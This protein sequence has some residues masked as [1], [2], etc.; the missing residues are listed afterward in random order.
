M[1]SLSARVFGLPAARVAL[2]GREADLEAVAELLTRDGVKLLTLTGAG[3]S[4]KTSLAL[5]VARRVGACF[6]QV[7]F[8]ELGAVTDCDAAALEIANVLG[9]RQ[10]D[11]RPRLLVLDNLEQIHGI[12]PLL[13]RLLD[14]SACLKLLVTSR[15]LLRI[16]PETHYLVAPLRVP[17]PQEA[18][19]P[20]ALAVNPAVALFMQ[21]AVAIEPSFRL[22]ADNAAAVAELCTQLDGL[23]L[24]LEL[25]AARIQVLSPAELLARM[26]SR[27]AL[28][29]T[30][31]AD[32]PPRHQTLRHTLDWSHALLDPRE[33]RLF[34]RLAVF[35]GGCT[36]ES[37]EAVC[38]TRGDVGLDVIDGLSSLLDK[39]LIVALT[40]AGDRRRF[41]M[42]MIV[43]EFAL[44]QLEASGEADRTRYAHAAY[45]V[46][47]AEEIAVR[48]SPQE[49]AEWLATCDVEH[50]NHRA[51]LSYLVAGGHA[52]WALRLAVALYR[53]W[54]HREYLGEG[55]AWFDAILDMPA[56]SARTIVRARA[57]NYAAA[58]TS[59][60]GNGQRSHAQQLEALAICREL[61]EEREAVAALNALAA[62]KRFHGD[63]AA[64][65][66]WAEQTLEACRG[67]GDRSA[68]AAALSNM[69]DVLL[70]VGRP[71]DARRTMEEAFRTFAELGDDVGMAWCCNHLGDIA[72]ALDERDEARLLYEGGSCMFDA[73][74]NGWGV[75]RS[76]CDLG[77]LACDGGDPGEARRQF[78][79]ALNGF[80]EVDHKRGIASALEGFARLGLQ[81][82]EPERAITLAAAATSLHQATGARA[83]ERDDRKLGRIRDLAFQAVDLEQSRAQWAAGLRMTADEAMRYALA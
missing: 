82:G 51:A 23:P 46:V 57:L 65:L 74:G 8:L 44:E 35:A 15:T 12:G 54:E 39:N 36:V 20:A 43:R 25:A 67:I 38:N 32:R 41:G 59:V 55:D 29:S 64:A 72:A 47:V 79:R 56:A 33:Q 4:G 53:Y 63:Y 69:G 16:G 34:R 18:A 2:I 19:S 50:D 68:M 40:P 73:V 27:L 6:E 48:K 60:Q 37:A 66:E 58:F 45:S 11:T 71:Q 52:E 70:L 75:A 7:Q 1:S 31:A 80:R 17:T 9:V 26:H 28:L 62:T 10:T 5:E 3:G 61:G 83:R 22:S 77:H 14:A 30:G 42:L 81:L 24:A 49:L 76:A 21:R 13:A 78:Q